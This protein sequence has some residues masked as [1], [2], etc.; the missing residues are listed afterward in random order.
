MTAIQHREAE[1]LLPVIKL[2]A[3]THKLLTYGTAAEALGRSRDNARM[4]AQVCDL[5]D[6]AA[7]YA[8]V[9]LLA[10]ITV[11][12]VSGDINRRAFAEEPTLCSAIIEQSLRHIFSEEDFLAISEALIKLDEKSNIAAWKF[13]NETIPRE[14]IHRRLTALG[15]PDSLDAID[16][17][18]TDTA[19]RVISSTT[20]Y[21]RDPRIR[22]AVI[23]RAAGRCEFCGKLG[24]VCVSGERYLECHH[25]ISLAN[26]GADR[27]TNVI[28]LCPNDHREA[29]FGERRESLE[30]EM[31][32]KVKVAENVANQKIN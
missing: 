19:A 22:A 25:I 14:E 29:H 7:V 12:E 9:P 20:R 26:D 28:A 13:I 3:A 31:I 32:R 11:R 8:G 17:I 16:D 2:A 21:A 18:G 24:F 4:V 5:L 10:L 15:P 1:K 30:E 27:M 6:A 23:H